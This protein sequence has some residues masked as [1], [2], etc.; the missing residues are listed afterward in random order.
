MLCATTIMH[1]VLCLPF[2][3]S[4]SDQN[5]RPF[6]CSFSVTNAS[7]FA[8]IV[9]EDK[10]TPVDCVVRLV[11]CLA[12]YN[13]PRTVL[14]L[15]I[16]E[17]DR[18]TIPKQQP[19][20]PRW[21]LEVHA[22]GTIW[23]D[24]HKESANTIEA[25]RRICS[26]TDRSCGCVRAHTRNSRRSSCSGRKC[27][28]FCYCLVAQHRLR[29]NE[30]KWRTQ[31]PLPRTLSQRCFPIA[32][33]ARSQLRIGDRSARQVANSRRLNVFSGSDP[34]TISNCFSAYCVRCMGE[35]ERRVTDL[36]C[37][38]EEALREERV[39]RIKRQLNA[40]DQVYLLNCYTL[41]QIDPLVCVCVTIL[42]T[43]FGRAVRWCE[44]SKHEWHK[45]D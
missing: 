31:S 37:G 24:H 34:K 12:A 44:C 8:F 32:F 9:R 40:I 39:G 3:S 18:Y 10:K 33:T 23:S 13:T 1:K 42:G 45:L 25:N 15:I 4:V 2:S 30:N 26:F 21:G 17:V 20:L 14:S 11:C 27:I 6:P 43:V 5:I 38:A 28:V 36:L 16:T 7:L 22:S 19:Q 41:L 35:Y 29:R